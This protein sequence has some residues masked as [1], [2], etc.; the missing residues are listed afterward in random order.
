MHRERE[1][2]PSRVRDTPELPSGYHEALDEGL[3]AM[4]LA[5]DPRARTAIDGH[6]RLLLAWTTAI[7]LTA[8]RDPVAAATAHVLDSLAG[9][10]PLRAR[11]IDAV[12]DLGSGGGLP[13]IPLAA[14]LPARDAV[15]VEPIGKKARFLATVLE[16]T[17]LDGPTRVAATRAETLAA[18]PHHRGRWAAVTARAV[19]ALAELVELGFPLLADG[20]L[21]VA[22]KRGD[23]DGELAAADRAIEA[24]GGGRLEVVDPAVPGLPEHRLVLVTRTGS[25]PA[26][27][28]RDPAA[29]ARRPW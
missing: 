5:L 10:A 3:A 27:Y 16:A 22:W 12:L 28:P 1:P 13:G 25:V 15:L 2:L 11:G 24:L 26:A 21:L 19:S 7:N 20:G 9:V 17:G 4:G 18:D 14:A 6:I 8:V 23:L 29:R